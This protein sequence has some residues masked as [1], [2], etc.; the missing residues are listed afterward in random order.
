[1]ANIGKAKIKVP[2]K[3]SK[4]QVVE[5]KAM[6]RHP[7][8]TGNRK[9]KKTGQKIPAHYIEDVEATFNGASVF[10]AKWGAAVSKN[11][12]LSFFLKV[13]QAGELKITWKDNKGGVYSATKKVA[14]K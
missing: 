10:S 9:N 6:V 3:I 11:P 2:R 12:F 4:G 1:M 7:M 13:D 14:L 8:E 5:V